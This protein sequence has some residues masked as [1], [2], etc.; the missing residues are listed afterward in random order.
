MPPI[1]HDNAHEVPLEVLHESFRAFVAT[2]WR[3]MAVSADNPYSGFS[4]CN[5]TG[6][7]A[8]H[9]D[10]CLR[11]LAQCCGVPAERVVVPRQTHGTQVLVLSRRDYNEGFSGVD[12]AQLAGIDAVVTDLRGVVAGVNTADCLPLVLIDEEAG[13]AG[14]VHAGWRG[15]VA[16]IAER[17][18]HE[19]VRLGADPRRV[20]ALMGPC[21]VAEEFEVGEE[22]A[23]RFPEAC[24]S[25][26]YGVKPHVDLPLAVAMQLRGCGVD[27]IALPPAGTLSRPDRYFSARALG[28]SSGRNFT[29]VLLK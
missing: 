26:A 28:V 13:V 20:K 25:R 17:A 1:Y 6:D 22:V 16:G 14:A 18:M 11:A 27:D 19:M 5:Y 24:V 10:G 7:E 29:F 2:T 15:A 21:I 3:G 23:A 8:A 12:E 4:L 9:C